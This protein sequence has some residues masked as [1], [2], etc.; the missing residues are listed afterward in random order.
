M[1]SGA[2]AIG[3]PEEC[4]TAASNPVVEYLPDRR[5]FVGGEEWAQNRVPMGLLL[6]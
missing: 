3:A 4:R 2:N 6:K 5:T 1:T